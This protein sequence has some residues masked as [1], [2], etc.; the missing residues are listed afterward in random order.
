MPITL[1][2]DL[3]TRL[4]ALGITSLLRPGIQMPDHLLLEPPCSLKWMSVSHS[5]ELGAFSYAVSGFYFGCRIGRYCS[6]GEQVQ[7]GRHPHPTHWFS[8]SPFFYQA[9]Q[10]ILDQPP[11]PGHE[12]TAHKDFPRKSPPVTAKTTVIGNDVWIGHGAFILPGVKIGDGAV[13]AAMSVVTKDVP[14]YS[15]VAGVPAV[16]KKMRFPEKRVERFLR[17]KWWE[18]A[19]WDLKGA[20]VDEFPAFFD[21]LAALR[22]RGAQPYTPERVDVAKLARE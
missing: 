14:P 15:V 20:P 9:Y 4:Q 11:P 7:I 21:F 18:F 1:T 17:T 6:F 22:E 19:P 3:M 13:I 2:Q 10:S 8:S 12:F 16:V 5:L